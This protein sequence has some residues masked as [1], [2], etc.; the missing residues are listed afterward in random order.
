MRLEQ[1]RLQ[2]HPGPYARTYFVLS[3]EHEPVGETVVSYGYIADAI[4]DLSSLWYGK[5][6]DVHGTLQEHGNL[7]C[8]HFPIRADRTSRCWPLPPYATAR[9]GDSA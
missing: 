8:S 3:L 2:M 5:R 9:L 7:L 1:V 4:A 6:F